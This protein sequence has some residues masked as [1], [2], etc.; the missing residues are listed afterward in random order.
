M[1]ASIWAIGTIRSQALRGPF[2][3]L[4]PSRVLGPRGDLALWATEGSG[5][6]AG[7]CGN[8]ER[9]R[10]WVGVRVLFEHTTCTQRYWVNKTAK[11]V[12][13]GGMTLAD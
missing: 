12:H 4:K 6:W 3:T 13:V 9:V 11:M 10:S 8:D 2:H 5:S 7:K 1:S